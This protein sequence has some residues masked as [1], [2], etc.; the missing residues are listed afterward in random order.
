M[1]RLRSLAG[2]VRHGYERTA[3]WFESGV[4]LL[5]RRY[6]PLGRFSPGP[7]EGWSFLWQP[8]LEGFL[9]LV[10]VLAGCSFTNSPFKLD[11]TST[12]FFGE[13]A[14]GFN[15]TPE[16]DQVPA[17]DRPGLRRTAAADARVAAPGRGHAAARGRAAVLAVVDARRSGRPHDRRA[18]AVQ[19]RRVQ[20]R[21]P[22][23]DDRPPHL[24]VLLRPL[25]AGRRARTP[26]SNRSTR[27]G[28]TPPPP[29]GRSSCSSTGPSTGSR[30]TTS[31]ARSSGCASSR[32]SRWASSAWA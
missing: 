23:R 14:G 16:R 10:M 18:P 28:A 29:T 21:R 17:V 22:G 7:F 31:S 27:C 4:Q 6:T 12:W 25:H 3:A 13:P 11:M 1:N 24:A 2:A 20:L 5:E 15:G 9:G 32:S 19:P 30:G 8:A 26:G